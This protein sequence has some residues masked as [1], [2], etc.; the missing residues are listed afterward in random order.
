M[1]ISFFSNHNINGYIN[2]VH[3]GK[4]ESVRK[5]AS[6]QNR[7]DK[8]KKSYLYLVITIL[9]G[10]NF[11][12]LFS[13]LLLE[14]YVAGVFAGEPNLIIK[15]FNNKHICGKRFGVMSF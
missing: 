6:V 3:N 14:V 13:L 12:H 2:H 10:T 11:S 7:R 8:Q 15:L 9:D 4:N 1:S 5:G